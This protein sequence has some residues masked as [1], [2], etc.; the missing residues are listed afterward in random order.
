MC[1]FDSL[2]FFIRFSMV[3][4]HRKRQLAQRKAVNANLSEKIDSTKPYC[5]LIRLIKS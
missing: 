2:A 1:F 3:Y 5:T 4:I